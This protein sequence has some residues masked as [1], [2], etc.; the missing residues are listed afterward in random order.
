MDSLSIWL[1]FHSSTFSLPQTLDT[2]QNLEIISI[3]KIIKKY[4]SE[5]IFMED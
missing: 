4:K 3:S 5:V 2:E 1:H